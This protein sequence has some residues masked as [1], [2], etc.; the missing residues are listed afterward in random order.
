M[1]LCSYDK[2]RTAKE[3]AYNLREN[4]KK[5]PNAYKP[6]STNDDKFLVTLHYK[7]RSIKELMSIFKRNEGAIQSRIKKLID[8]ANR[9]K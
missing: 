3:K 8:K 9:E 6:W 5:Y 1:S 7:G 4:R 2:K